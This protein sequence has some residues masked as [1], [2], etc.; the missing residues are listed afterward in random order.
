[1]RLLRGD[2]DVSSENSE[3]QEYNGSV[4]TTN[5]ILAFAEMTARFVSATRSTTLLQLTTPH[6]SPS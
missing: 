2:D 3:C 1:M 4:H 6:T 5:C